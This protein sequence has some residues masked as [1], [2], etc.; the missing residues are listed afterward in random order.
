M[1]IILFDIDCLRPD[2]LR[3][4][5]YGRPTSPTIDWVAERG[6]RFT[7][8]C[9]ADS[10]C[11]PSRM[12]FMSGRFGARNG[13][14]SNIGAGA[15]FHIRHTAYRG[16]EP[17][18]EMLM[19]QLRRAGCDPISFSNFADRHCAMWFMCG[20]SEFHTINLKGGGEDAAEVNEKVLRWLKDNATRE[21]YLLHINYWDTHRPYRMDAS[22]A[23]RFKDHP[24]AQ[25]W[26]DEEAIQ[27][28]QSIDAPFTAR[29]QF[30]DNVSPY[31]LMPGAVR[32][33]AEFE[34]MITG[35]DA[36]IAYVDHHMKR[37]L[38]EL[39]RQGVLDD[40]AVII[41]SDH[42]DAFGEHGVYSDHVCADECIHNIPLIV[43]WPGLTPPESHC[44]S[45]IYN[46]D[47]SATLCDL[48]G[49]PIPADW[50]GRSFKENLAGRTGLERGYLVWGHGLY[51]VQRAVR[52]RDRLMIRSDD[53][54][55][56]RMEPVELYDMEN[57][58]YQTRNL[59]DEEPQTV[60]RCDHLLNEWLQEQREKPH[61]I[62]DPMVLT[63][64]ER[65]AERS[66]RRG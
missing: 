45:M 43:R 52:T 21:N 3:C 6:V 64:Q 41:T 60:E 12:G 32:N 5:G 2:H 8:Y 40:A 53:R 24:V 13:V 16:P 4:Y 61:P 37:V 44:D 63:L 33:R 11:L 14:T 62:P 20:W 59:R 35:Y 58:R 39:D 1:R 38:D 36:S 28:H 54:M 22:W 17:D 55:T 49:A 18:N 56:Y 57:D 31:P 15:R 10:P 66:R 29:R 46:I 48:L 50:D 23:D 9:C 47:L 42:G 30:K 25:P 34:H 27:R 26:P 65:S 19:R 51:T 7:R